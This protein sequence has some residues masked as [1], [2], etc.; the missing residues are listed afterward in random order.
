MWATME[1]L[2]QNWIGYVAVAVCLIPMV[3]VLRHTVAPLV[4]YAIEL[5]AYFV[6]LHLVLFGVVKLAR[7]FHVN[8]RMYW[9]RDQP[10]PSWGIPVYEFWKPQSY[11][12]RWF[13]YLELVLVVV[14]IVLM[15]KYRPLRPQKPPPSR[16]HV[17]KGTGIRPSGY[18][19][20]ARSQ[21]E[22]GKGR[23]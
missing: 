23:R 15:Y 3:Y 12:P 9:L 16:K 4:L 8:S 13:F 21:K 11:D 18:L 1:H 7:W 6:G 22:R 20:E 19:A 10:E 5:A 17:A 14:V 2:Q